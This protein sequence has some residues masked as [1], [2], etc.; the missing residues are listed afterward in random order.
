MTPAA[1]DREVKD[2][3]VKMTYF[4][5]T[6]KKPALKISTSDHLKSSVNSSGK[7]SSTSKTKSK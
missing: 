2:K 1:L 6:K 3:E 5:E 7:S 4:V